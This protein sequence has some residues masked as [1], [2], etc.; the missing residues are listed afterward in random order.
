M[1]RAASF[2]VALLLALLPVT[3]AAQ[4]ADVLTGRIVGIDGRPVAGARVEAVSIETEISRSV[5]SDANGRYML[6]FPDGGGRY[7]LRVTMLGMADIV[8][9]VVREDEELLLTNITLSPQAIELAGINV[10]A[11]APTPGQGNAGEQSTDLPQDLLNRLPLPDLD[12]ST[13]ALLAAGVVGTELDSLSGRMGF[14][15]AGMSDL[16]NQITLDGM[17]LGEGGLQIPEEGVRRTQ[18]TTNTFDA[19]RGGFAGGQV[20]MSSARGNNRTAGSLSYRLDD[21]ALQAQATPLTN[22]FTRHNFG[23]SIGGPI[24]RNRLFY[25]ASFQL[26]HN[27][28]HRFAL[29]AN[30]PLAAQRAGVNVDSISR[31]LDILSLAHGF[32]VE[33]QTGAYNQFN[34]DLRLQG[35]V[36]WNIT[37]ARATSQTLS[38]RFN[39]NVRDQDST[40]IQTLDLA[41]HGGETEQNNRLGSLTLNSRFGSGWTNALSLSFNESWNDQ[42]PYLEMPEGRV[43]VTSEFEDGVRDTRSLVFGGN[44][45]MPREAYNR[46]LQLQNDVSLLLP[47]GNHLHRLKVGGTLQ[48]AR[49]VARSTDNLFGSFTFASLAD[50]EANLPERYERSLAAREERTGTYNAGLYLGDTWRISQPLEVTL[51]LRWDY[52]QLDQKPEHNPVVEQLFGRRTDIDPVASSFSPRIGF[53]YRLSQSGQPS[54]SLTGGVGVFAGRAPTSI[55]SAAT[56][57]TGLPNAEQRLV[58]IGQAVPVPD[59]DLYLSD[60]FAVPETCADGAPGVPDAFSSRAPTVTLIDPDQA[61][62]SSL[63]FDLGYRTRLPFNLNANFRYNYARGFGLWGYRDINLDDAGS[64]ALGDGR[65][66]FGDVSAI[67]PRTGAVSMTTSRLHDTFGN[68]YDVVADRASTSHELTAQVNGYLFSKLLVNANYR[69]GFARDQG[70][71]SFAQATT[72]GNPNQVEWATSGNDRRHNLNLTLGYAITPE[73][74]LTLIGRVS[75]G[76]PFTPMV[77]RDINGD[78]VRNDRA[79]VF[80]PAMTQDTAIANGMTRLL[81]HVPGRV[82]DCLEEQL[83]GIAGRNSCRNGW[84]QSLDFRTSIRPNLPRVGR[85]LTVSIDGRNALTGLDQLINGR[86]GMKGWGEGQRAESN[87]LEVRGFDPVAQHYLYEVNEGFGQTNRGPNAFRNAFSLTISARLAIGGQAFQNNRGFGSIAGLGGG[88]GGR[89]GFGGGDRGGFGGRGG[90]GDAGGLGE[91]GA[92]IRGNLDETQ[93]AAII[94]RMIPNPVD[95]ILA[96][97]HSLALT[98]EQDASLRTIADTLRA[99]HGRRKEVLTEAAR[100][101]LPQLAGAGSVANGGNGRGGRGG[102]AGIN[103][104]M[105]QRL[106]TDLQ[107][108]IEGART[109]STEALRL[110]QEA[111]QPEQWARIPETVRDPSIRPVQQG[112]GR[113]GFNA[114]GMID[115]MLANPIPVLLTLKDTLKLTPEQVTAIEAVSAQLQTNLNARRESLGKRFDNVEGGQ[116]GRIFQEAQP[117]I[118]A[119]RKEVT[120][121]LAAVQTL[122]SADQWNQLPERIRTPF[123]NQGRGGR[124]GGG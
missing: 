25:N 77:D 98:A 66:F 14:S 87:L 10:R 37:Q 124:R 52:S 110:V 15:V 115:R 59:W 1:R 39:T 92:L 24:V 58:C 32:P 101:L 48:K 28:D 104:E 82:A 117:E 3:A 120:D 72:A 69:L 96:I 34:D 19:S 26:Q 50:F 64:F 44:R 88:G 106:Q 12:P 116:Q 118:E 114:V 74:E 119:A 2:F 102:G 9:T 90:F 8:Q 7:V 54:K 46:N 22:A 45:S 33:G 60:P 49:Q 121:A 109:E 86:N 47:V 67:D 55:F 68:V 89:G 65:P 123:A 91:L 122:L 51:G 63:R 29:A 80:D 6:L 43:R 81:A 105:I 107:P 36:D 111:L 62:P 40:R 100:T 78:G 84:S 13:L 18:V 93:I 20:A 83:G 108:Q 85:R 17:I 41:Q 31:F 61:M 21:D 103:P 99:Q 11:Q 75:S 79:F 97:N 56:R 4:E 23:G 94:D 76:S 42:L 35:R 5:L 113:G 30:D 73:V 57:Q 70:S 71:G 38:L 112:G 53:S 95:S 16:L 27:V